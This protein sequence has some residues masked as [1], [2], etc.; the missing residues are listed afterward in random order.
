MKVLCVFIKQ[1]PNALIYEP[2]RTKCVLLASGMAPVKKAPV[3]KPPVDLAATSK[4]IYPSEH[5]TR[6]KVVVS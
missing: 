2:T 3:Q 5:E 1:G 6:W 4:K